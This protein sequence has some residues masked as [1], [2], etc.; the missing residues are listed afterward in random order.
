[1]YYLLIVCL[2][3]CIKAQGVNVKDI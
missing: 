3:T 1:M 2:Y